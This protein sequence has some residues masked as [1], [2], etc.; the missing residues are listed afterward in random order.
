MKH[1]HGILSRSDTDEIILVKPDHCFNN[2]VKKTI[3]CDI[4]TT[5]MNKFVL[6]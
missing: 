5:T 1:L 4:K 2:V 6:I 3:L